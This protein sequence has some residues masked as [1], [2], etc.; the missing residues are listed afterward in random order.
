MVLDF[1]G[2][3]SVCAGVLLGFW[4]F[5]CLTSLQFVLSYTLVLPCVDLCDFTMACTRYHNLGDMEVD[6]L[7]DVLDAVH[8]LSLRADAVSCLI[9]ATHMYG[10][11]SLIARRR[12]LDICQEFMTL[13]LE[14]SRISEFLS[15]ILRHTDYPDDFL[16]D[17]LNWPL[18]SAKY[19][20]LRR[21]SDL[22]P[23]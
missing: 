5:A 19:P 22:L 18:V 17:N 9:P 21:L 6:R 20:S 10:D 4:Y 23:I 12:V 14:H 7:A 16:T 15:S 2:P 3:A 1:I 13:E 8:A 11:L